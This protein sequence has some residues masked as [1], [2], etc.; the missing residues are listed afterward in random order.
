MS[1]L[2]N[3]P[4][5][6]YLTE[7]CT[8]LG[9]IPLYDEKTS[10][11]VHHVSLQPLWVV[12][13]TVAQFMGT[14][15]GVSKKTARHRAAL[16]VLDQIQSSVL[17]GVLASFP[18]SFAAYFSTGA[19]NQHGNMSLDLDN[20]LNRENGINEKMGLRPIKKEGLSS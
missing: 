8:E 4:P 9:I 11:D 19:V 14:G 18:A 2:L 6:C 16:S 7:L 13:V 15:K 17:A 3:K 20:A 5:I 1:Y 10:A 12:Q